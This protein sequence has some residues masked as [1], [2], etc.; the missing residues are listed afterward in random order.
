L[1]AAQNANHPALQATITVDDEPPIKRKAHVIVVGNVGFLQANIQ[2]IPGARADDGLLDVL[3]ASPRGIRDWVRITTQVL[4]RQRRTDAQVDRLIGR[5]V[6]ISVDGRDHFQVDGDTVGECS[7]MTAEV[8]P[9]ALTMRVPRTAGP[10]RTL[11][12]ELPSEELAST[13][14][15]SESADV[16]GRLAHRA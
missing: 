10:A 4:T 1:S 2:L 12:Y 7:T 14:G 5:K 16:P 15:A 8:R 13:N 11:P 6:T 9:G 3:V